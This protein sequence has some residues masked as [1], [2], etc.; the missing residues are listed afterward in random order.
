MSDSL[1]IYSAVKWEFHN[2]ISYPEVAHYKNDMCDNNTYK[3]WL[4]ALCM[5]LSIPD[6]I[7]KKTILFL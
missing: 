3:Q 4:N 6:F 5:L 1:W 7:E 2:E